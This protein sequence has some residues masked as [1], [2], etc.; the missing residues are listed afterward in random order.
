[1]ERFLYDKRLENKKSWIDAIK[2]ILCK[3]KPELAVALHQPFHI[4]S[5]PAKTKHLGRYKFW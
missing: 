4:A 5:K 3:E 2:Y 1:M